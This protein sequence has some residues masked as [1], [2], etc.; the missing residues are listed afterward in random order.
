MKSKRLLPLILL[1]TVL[2]PMLLPAQE[3][4]SPITPPIDSLTRYGLEPGKLYSAELVAQLLDAAIEEGRAIVKDEVA[5]AYDKGYKAGAQDY[6]PD[7]AWWKAMSQAWKEEAKPGPTWG[8][9]AVG[10]GAGLIVGASASA[11]L[12]L[13][14]LAQ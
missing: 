12:A 14:F 9:V 6:G 10:A 1:L 4:T 8:T 11:I 2:S 3:T 5:K 7:A 13:L